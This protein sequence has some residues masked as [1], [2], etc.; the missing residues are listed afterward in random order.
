M[1]VV[2]K[3][4]NIYICVY[5]ISKEYDIMISEHLIRTFHDSDVYF[6]FYFHQFYLHGK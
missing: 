3:S 4:I 2:S 5:R 1:Y 6:I